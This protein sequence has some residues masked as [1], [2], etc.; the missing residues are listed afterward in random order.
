MHGVEVGE[1]TLPDCG[2]DFPNLTVLN[3]GGQVL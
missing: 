2:L 1:T 3:V